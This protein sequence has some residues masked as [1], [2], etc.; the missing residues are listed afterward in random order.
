MLASFL[1]FIFANSFSFESLPSSGCGFRFPAGQLFSLQTLKFRFG[2]PCGF[3]FCFSLQAFGLFGFLAKDLDVS[4]VRVNFRY[5][6]K[7]VEGFLILRLVVRL[8]T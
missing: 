4:I 8:L 5:G 6:P 2:P 1:L 3:F 7:A